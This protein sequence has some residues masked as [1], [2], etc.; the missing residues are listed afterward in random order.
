MN[1]CSPDNE[2]AAMPGHIL[3]DLARNECASR[4]WRKAAAKLLLDKGFHQAAH[5]DL[6]FLVA[7]IRSE[8]TAE[9]EVEAVVEA[10]IEGEIQQPKP[11][12]PAEVVFQQTH[13]GE[14]IPPH[15]G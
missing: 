13:D 4:E 6:A 3:F 1:Q 15:C 14:P 5:P 2:L 7:E 8:R 12:P 10:A 11:V 9:T